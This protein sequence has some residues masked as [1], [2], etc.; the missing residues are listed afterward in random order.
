MEE[1]D[2]DSF[3]D[4]EIEWSSYAY[5]IAAARNLERILATDNIV[6]PEDPRTYN[7]DALLVN[8][9]LHLPPSKVANFDLSGTFDE[10]MFQAHM[11]TDL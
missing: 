4:E 1:F 7:L 11:I 3:L 2:D 5:R 9:N 6:F 10:M 8:W